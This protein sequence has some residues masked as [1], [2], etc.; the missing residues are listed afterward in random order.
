MVDLK[1]F[2]VLYRMK[3]ENYLLTALYYSKLFHYENGSLY[4]DHEVINL[5]D[6]TVN[7]VLYD[8]HFPFAYYNGFYYFRDYKEISEPRF[9]KVNV[10]TKESE[11]IY[12]SM[13]KGQQPVFRLIAKRHGNHLVCS[14]YLAHRKG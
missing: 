2:S 14:T 12:F 8:F 6:K 10:K 4:L 11:T 9:T 13:E 1:S 5:Q 7:K 3:N